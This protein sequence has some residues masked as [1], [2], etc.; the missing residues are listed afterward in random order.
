MLL[1]PDALSLRREGDADG[2]SG[3]QESAADAYAWESVGVAPASLRTGLAVRIAAVRIGPTLEESR[4]FL[5]Q[6]MVSL[7]W[8][9]MT[10]SAGD[11]A[12]PTRFVR[13]G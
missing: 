13:A 10:L 2:S 5:A 1:A 11:P 6:G 4:R 12:I 8:E 3:R 9:G 7:P